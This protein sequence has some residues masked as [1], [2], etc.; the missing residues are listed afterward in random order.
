MSDSIVQVKFSGDTSRLNAAVS[1][2][3]KTIQGYASTTGDLQGTLDRLNRSIDANTEAVHGTTEA[4]ESQNSVLGVNVVKWAAVIYVLSEAKAALEAFVE[5]N[6]ATTGMLLGS[7]WS[8]QKADVQADK[9][10]VAA[11]GQA[12]SGAAG[13]VV[14]AGQR[15]KAA[16][17]D[18]VQGLR[19]FA[20]SHGLMIGSFADEAALMAVAAAGGLDALQAEIAL[21]AA[22]TRAKMRQME[23]DYVHAMRVFE[24]RAPGQS[25]PDDLS[26]HPDAGRADRPDPLPTLD[27][28]PMNS[29]ALPSRQETDM[30]RGHE[31]DMARMEASIRSAD[32]VLKG[33]IADLQEIPDTS[34]EVATGIEAGFTTIPGYTLAANE[35]MIELT[36]ASADSGAEAQ[37][38][39]KA[40]VAA[41]TDAEAG[42][43]KVATM[44]GKIDDADR[45]IDLAKTF[46]KSMAPQQAVTL[47]DTIR[48]GLEAQRAGLQAVDADY[49]AQQ[50]KLNAVGRLIDGIV[51]S[52][53]A[54]HAARQA[55]IG[56]LGEENGL[57]EEQSRIYGD[58]ARKV[59]AQKAFVEA[60]HAS[61]TPTGKID[62]LTRTR[63]ALESRPQRTMD[64]SGVTDEQKDF[65][66]RLAILEAGG[67]IA[68]GLEGVVDVFRNRLASGKFG[69]DLDAVLTKPKQF[70]AYK[71]DPTTGRDARIDAIDPDSEQY[72]RT[73]AMVDKQFG[74][75]P[76]ADV[77]KGATHYLN[78]QT[79]TDRSWI[80]DMTN[81]T[82]IGNHKFGNVGTDPVD[83]DDTERRRREA[84]QQ[85]NDALAQ[86]QAILAGGTA[87]ARANLEIAQQQA[88]GLRDQVDEARQLVAARQREV[89]EAA[90]G[91]PV[92]RNEAAEALAKAQSALTAKELEESVSAAKLEAAAYE[93]GT[94][95]R[96]AAENAAL[97]QKLVGLRQGSAEYNAIQEEM[98]ANT[99]K[100]AAQ[101]TQESVAA[102]KVQATAY[103]EG[104]FERAAADNQA[105]ALKLVG[106][107]QES[108]EYQ[109][110]LEQMIANTKKAL[111]QQ[112]QDQ[113]EA[114]DA[115]YQNSKRRFE[116]KLA[117]IK[118]LA[119]EGKISGAQGLAQTLAV[120]AQMASA[121]RA[122]Q[123]TRM[124]IFGEETREYRK[125]K[126]EEAQIA[127][128]TRQKDLA[129]QREHDKQLE[130]SIRGSFEGV[131][132]TVSSSLMAILEKT[133]TFRQ[134]MVNVGKT[135]AQQFLNSAVKM[136]AD[137]AAQQA[138]MVVKSVAF[139]NLQTAA[140]T[141]GEAARTGAMAS[142][143]AVQDAVVGS[144]VVRSIL[145]SASET[146]AGIFGFLSPVMGPAAAGPAAAGQAAVAGMASFAVGAWNLPSDMVAQVHA[147]E[148]IVPAGPAAAMRNALGGAGAGSAGGGGDVHSHAHFNVTAMDSRDVRRFFSDNSKHIMGAINDG[149]RTGSH[150]GLRKL[151]SP[152]GA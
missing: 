151:G 134:L 107:R 128:Q 105:L 138:L 140:V 111:A 20:M 106:M 35:A 73:R 17:G 72:Q 127:E 100:A 65:A 83:S 25:G 9:D 55:T 53:Q 36:K 78:P 93:E 76:N 81:T 89:D 121:D 30:T 142:A 135:I 145:A 59:A 43:L 149:I 103:Q 91:T 87:S 2:A 85:T 104:T 51:G 40:F 99:K 64:E 147:G 101:E 86:Q 31:D 56:T 8:I 115:D 79:A 80:D 102:A 88:D 13:L 27:V 96:V 23:D 98:I 74:P 50:G 117:D 1:D 125:A 77:T 143:G 75:E 114:A 14:I 141:A 58:I 48:K 144:S 84:V 15:I 66:T 97:A 6:V 19:G 129:A 133:G 52:T 62:D 120:D 112:K 152:I 47:F 136:V 3:R 148:M 109:G 68:Q 67:E 61:S 41:L 71:P 95:E 28:I 32:E 45:R 63:T 110:V 11:V 33:F 69:A 46:A 94:F 34:R 139:Q 108:A 7:T 132:S 150:L 70:S 57:L 21:T 126:L 119:A 60:I 92:K 49:E 10:A 29:P 4:V 26:P 22:E 137:W 18:A 82:T 24:T 44:L 42:G 37:A 146:F 5:T 38:F 90:G 123:Q 54:E 122:Y 12:A 113:A 130:Q 16:Y 118:A 116:E 39:G 124:Q 131:G